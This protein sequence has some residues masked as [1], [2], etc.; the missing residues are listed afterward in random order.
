MLLDSSYGSQTSHFGGGS[1]AKKLINCFTDASFTTL[2]NGK[3][4]S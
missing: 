2:A 1:D 4:Y 3:K